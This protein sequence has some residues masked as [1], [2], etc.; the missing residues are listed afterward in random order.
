MLF[1]LL[2]F[3]SCMF[4]LAG[5]SVAPV[6]PLADAQIWQ[7]AE[8]KYQPQHVT[9]TL[10]TL[11]D[12][13]ESVQQGLKTADRRNYSTERRLDQ[14]LSELYDQNGIR[15]S[16]ATGHSTGAAQTWADRRGDCLSL[17]ILVYAAA[18]SLGLAPHMQEVRVPVLIDRR[19]GVDFINGHVNVFVRTHS[20]ISINGRSLQSGGIIIDFDPQTGSQHMGQSLT[21]REVLARFYNNRAS[22]YLVQRDDEKAYAY[23]R[24]A[25]AADPN[26]G[27]AFA[28]LA[29]L[30]QR[31]GLLQ[32]A[33][34]LLRHAIA[35]QGPSYAPLRAMHELL[36]AQGRGTEAEYYANLLQRR[37][38][39]DP[40]YWLG[41]GLAALHD[42]R[43]ESAIRDLEQA[44]SLTT[45]FEEI[46]LSLALAYWHSGQREAA[47]QQLKLLTA[48]N[49]KDPNIALLNKKMQP[50]APATQT[51]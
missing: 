31:R 25:I 43:F 29:Q 1:R 46:H 20:E 14:L 27:P 35:L 3:N 16:Y 51:R 5:C 4:A 45:G 37:Q 39:L 19:D 9:E 13:D 6:A 7:D 18:K 32:I 28:N 23:Y 24:S 15:L 30:Y 12:L 44:A 17:T 36:Q 48:L 50:S 21:E 34:Q 8:F 40:Y 41:I 38:A 49:S 42:R 11:F 10:G 2:I 47:Q 26:F 22:E 33:E